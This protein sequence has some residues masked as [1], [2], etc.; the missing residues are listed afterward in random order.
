ML[1]YLHSANTLETVVCLAP[2]DYSPGTSDMGS[3]NS[4]SPVFEV[5]PPLLPNWDISPFLERPRLPLQR[6]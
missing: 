3:Q 6:D 5:N 2:R 1:D 4:V